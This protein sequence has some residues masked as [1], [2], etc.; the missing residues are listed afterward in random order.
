MLTPIFVMETKMISR[1]NF[2]APLRQEIWQKKCFTVLLMAN[3]LK[4]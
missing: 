2:G 4:I 1:N 3:I